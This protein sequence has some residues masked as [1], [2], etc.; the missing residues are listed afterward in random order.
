MYTGIFLTGLTGLYGIDVYFLDLVVCHGKTA[1]R[2]AISMNADIAS[3]VGGFAFSTYLN[4]L[5]S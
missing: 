3:E 4:G 5:G 2:Y 1:Y